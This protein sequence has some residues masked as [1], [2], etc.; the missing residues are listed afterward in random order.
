MCEVS[1]AS[2]S[3]IKNMARFGRGVY[4]PVVLAFRRQRQED[5]IAASWSLA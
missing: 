5:Q 3:H 2:R 4:L 1:C